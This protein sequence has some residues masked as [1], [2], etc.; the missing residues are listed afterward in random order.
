MKQ[1]IRRLAR[2]EHQAVSHSTSTSYRQMTL[3]SA[4]ALPRGGPIVALLEDETPLEGL[5]LSVRA[6][7][8]L[9][10]SGILTVG[11]LA[12]MEPA[13]I[14]SLRNVGEE[15]A[16][17]IET[18]L[19]RYLRNTHPTELFT[20]PPVG[21]SSTLSS[22]MDGQLT[23][24]LLEDAA[25]I[26]VLDLS[27]R[28]FNALYRAGYHTV[29]QVAALSAEQLYSVRNIAAITIAE[30][31]ARLK[32]RLLELGSRDAILAPVPV[33]PAD[34]LQHQ[35]GS[36]FPAEHAALSASPDQLHRAEL[37]DATLAEIVN[38]WLTVLNERQRE[39]IRLRFGLEGEWLTL[40]EVGKR[41]GVTRE[42]VRQIEAA[43]LRLLVNRYR[44][45]RSCL[46]RPFGSALRDILIERGGI[47]TEF[48]FGDWIDGGGVVKR[49]DINI[50]TVLELLAKVDEKFIWVRRKRLLVHYSVPLTM[51]DEVE[52]TMR[53]LLQQDVRAMTEDELWEAFPQTD[54]FYVLSEALQSQNPLTVESFAKACIRTADSFERDEFRAYRLQ[55][56]ANSIVDKIV[57]ALRE[58]GSPAHFT[59]VTERVNSLLPAGKKAK[60]H[61][62]HAHLSRYDNIFAR[63]GHGVFGLVEWGLVNDGNLANAVERVL[64]AANKP[65]HIDVITRE[66]LKTWYVN[67]GSVYAAIQSD[68]RFASLGSAVYYLRNRVGA[69]GASHT[70]EFADLFG[71]QL[72]TWQ[73]QLPNGGGVS[74]PRD[75]HD[76]VNVLRNIGLDL[77]AD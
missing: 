18:T 31:E 62:V 24:P 27:R 2:R 5:G 69:G 50:T 34:Q 28:T 57:A 66:V 67:A 49:G 71:D 39:V 60:P 22:Q 64:T 54:T 42:R 26:L 11:R 43:A 23:A 4:T 1:P 63:V 30:I 7:N 48:E 35:I 21:T 77:F 10:R 65:L 9:A 32:D 72:T 58:I 6:Y 75:L 51:I 15:T 33:E 12:S 46:I 53:Q 25:P 44:T 40:A 8:A 38:Q 68:E 20:Q 52:Q 37:R 45:G 36:Q 3:P 29:G 47:M 61:N 55:R 76:E 70:S 73:E 19:E 74:V 59:L 17:E 14:L 13:A 41:F 16:R 56:R